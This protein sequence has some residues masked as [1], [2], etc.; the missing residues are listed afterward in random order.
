LTQSENS[1]AG[2]T[3]RAQIADLLQAGERRIAN[4][5]EHLERSLAHTPD[6]E[7]Q[8]GQDALRIEQ[9]SF[10]EALSLLVGSQKGGQA[11][12]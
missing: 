8:R 12:E 11:E 3:H 10:L 2:F 7:A 5:R 9:E 4:A 1:L 6:Q